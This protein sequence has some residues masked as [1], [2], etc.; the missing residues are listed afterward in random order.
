[1]K[2]VRKEFDYLRQSRVRTFSRVSRT[3]EGLEANHGRC[4]NG[5]IHIKVSVLHLRGRNI[6]GVCHGFIR[7][8]FATRPLR[9]RAALELQTEL[10]GVGEISGIFSLLSLIREVRHERLVSGPVARDAIAIEVISLEKGAKHRRE[11]S[12]Q[13]IRENYF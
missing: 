8:E 12:F 4:N 10:Y 9:E 1:M 3:S 13:E 5:I 6:V 2:G 7:E 11:K